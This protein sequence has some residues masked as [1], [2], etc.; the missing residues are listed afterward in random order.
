M[1][2]SEMVPAFN[3]FLAVNLLLILGLV[4]ATP[5]TSARAVS[6]DSSCGGSAGYTCLG[7]SFGNCCSAYGWC[8]STD[9]YCGTG[10]QSAFGTCG[11]NPASSSVEPSQPPSTSSTVAPSKSVSPDSSCGGSNGYTCAGSTFGTCCSQWAYWL[12]CFVYL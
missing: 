3:L 4:S 8:G 7:S 2:I 12:V 11:S 6:P 5:A 1:K 10:C 9:A